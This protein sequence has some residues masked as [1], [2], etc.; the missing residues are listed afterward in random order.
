M[1]LENTWISGLSS[2]YGRRHTTMPPFSVNA[3]HLTGSHFGFIVH[4]DVFLLFLLFERQTKSTSWREINST[5]VRN[6]KR[7]LKFAVHRD[8]EG[9]LNDSG[10]STF[11]SRWK[12]WLEWRQTSPQRED[13]VHFYNQDNNKRLC[14]CG[15]DVSFL[16]NEALDNHAPIKSP[17]WTSCTRFYLWLPPF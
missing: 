8:W 11:H 14:Q 13:G 6:R 15:A 9:R 12:A 5:K 16:P 4:F 2:K 3:Y 10:P 17:L 7:A 1:W